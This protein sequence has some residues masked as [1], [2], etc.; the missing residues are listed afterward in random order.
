[1]DNEIERAMMVLLDKIVQSVK[2]EEAL[3]LTQSTLNLA[4]IRQAY[5]DTAKKRV[6]N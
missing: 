3:K 2:P 1:M 5:T 6:S 4:H